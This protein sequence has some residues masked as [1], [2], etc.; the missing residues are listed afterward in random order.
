[1]AGKVKKKKKEIQAKE[2]GNGVPLPNS[3]PSSPPAKD[4]TVLLSRQ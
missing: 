3:P 4:S 2:S 1:M